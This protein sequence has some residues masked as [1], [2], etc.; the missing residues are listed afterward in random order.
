MRIE[1]GK[2]MKNG[3]YWFP[4]SEPEIRR[5]AKIIRRPELIL[6]R[7]D[8]GAMMNRWRETAGIERHKDI[9]ENLGMPWADIW[10]LNATWAGD[11]S[12][13]AFP[14][15][16]G[17]DSDESAPCGI[18]LRT[19]D[20]KKFAVTGSKSG[21]FFPWRCLF[22]STVK[23]D[24]TRVFVCE[25][26]TDTIACLGM[27]LFA[28]GRASCRGGEEQVISVVDQLAREV[29]IVSDN[30]G[31]GAE[32]ADCL[33]RAIQKPVYRLTPP[34]KDMRAFVRDGGTKAILETLLKNSF[35]KNS[36]E[37]TR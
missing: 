1:G 16:D 3:G 27:G 23:W 12:A 14:M 29:V 30:D 36:T 8:F 26:P 4:F 37:K 33:A 13:M 34:S 2:M 7:P 5:E 15:Y 25:G 21:I 20:G 32:G 31:P 17:G 9:A 19:M 35:R 22:S 24:I 28:I 11:R 10:W 6:Q 18:R